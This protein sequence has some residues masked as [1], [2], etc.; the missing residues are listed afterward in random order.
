[1]G[2]LNITTGLAELQKLFNKMKEVYFVAA[3][4]TELGTLAGFD[5]ELPVIDDGI[6]FNTGEADVATVK[7]TTGE[8]WTSY[9]KAGDPDIS[10]QV[11]S[12]AGV[13]NDLLMNK[14]GV[15]RTMAN[16][17]GDTGAETYEGQGYD[18]APKKTTGALFFRSEDK[19]SAIWLP[20]VEMYASFVVET[21]KPAYFNVKITPLA[22]KDGAAI[23]PLMRTAAA[24]AGS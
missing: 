6:S 19:Q 4:N 2:K 21:D 1:M 24:Q 12:I 3:A 20:N 16:G 13:V 7:L 18:L 5:M 15:K 14:R 22:G 11:A 8:N 9:G 17:F 10:I 23:V